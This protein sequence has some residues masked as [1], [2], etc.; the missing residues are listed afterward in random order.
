MA[1]LSED[2][3]HGCPIRYAAKVLGDA[4]AL[5]ILRDMVFKGSRHFG[6]FVAAPEGVSTNI[7]TDRLKRLETAGIVERRRDPEKAVRVIYE[8]TEKGRDLVPVLLAMIQWSSAWDE[9]AEVPAEFRQALS[10]EPVA[11]AS[12]IKAALA[13]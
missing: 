6:D 4:W 7:L 11:F 8:L 13:H 10:E 2:D 12:A 9:A 1:K 5:L 3:W